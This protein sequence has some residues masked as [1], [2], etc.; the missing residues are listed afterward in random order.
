M[1]V[2]VVGPAYELTTSLVYWR[3]VA[4]CPHIHKQTNNYCLLNTS[5]ECLCMQEIT[6]RMQEITNRMQEITDRMHV[7]SHTH[8]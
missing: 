8:F 6:N 1:H 4:T 2:L 5:V 7:H 3:H